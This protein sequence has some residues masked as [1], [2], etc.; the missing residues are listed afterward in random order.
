MI[1][2]RAVLLSKIINGL[3]IILN[4]SLGLIPT[5]QL[6]VLFRFPLHRYAP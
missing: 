3:G 2:M 6:Q 1:T 5:L 4:S